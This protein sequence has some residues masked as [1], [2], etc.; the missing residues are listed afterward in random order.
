MRRTPVGQTVTE[1]YGVLQ[2]ATGAGFS[3][4]HLFPTCYH[5]LPK[6]CPFSLSEGTKMGTVFFASG[7]RPTPPYPTPPYPYLKISRPGASGRRFLP[8]HK[9]ITNPFHVASAKSEVHGVPFPPASVTTLFT[10]A[11]PHKFPQPRIG[12]HIGTPT[13]KKFS[14]FSNDWRSLCK[15]TTYHNYPKSSV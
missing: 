4:S 14:S 11:S 10:R 9:I 12:S 15:S 1:R 7:W 6:L 5:V 2:S 3:A 8:Q 13:F